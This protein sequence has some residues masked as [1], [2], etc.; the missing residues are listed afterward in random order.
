MRTRIVI[1]PRH[2]IRRH[3]PHPEVYGESIVELE[4]GMATDVYTDPKG[5]LYTQTNDE[6]LIPYLLENKTREQRIILKSGRVTLKS[7]SRKDT[8]LIHGW[9]LTAPFRRAQCV[10]NEIDVVCEYISHARTMNSDLFVI[11]VRNHPVG[12]IGYTIIDHAG[13]L[14]CDIH[15]HSD[16]THED[17]NEA[18]KQLKDHVSERYELEKL[19][20][21]VFDHE[22][23]MQDALEK[24]MFERSECVPILIP[25]L[26]GHMRQTEYVAPIIR[27]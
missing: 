10:E 26:T 9:F 18:L 4:N 20:L 8:D 27:T 1:V 22:C 6:R 13:I 7:V 21:R 16:T 14:G 23:F 12:L 17:V 5:R 2:L 19:V 15:R 3:W 24:S 11:S 25:T